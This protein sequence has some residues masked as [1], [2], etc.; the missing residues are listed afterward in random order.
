M[1]FSP[2]LY[3]EDKPFLIGNGL[4][5]GSI[6]AQGSKKWL[7]YLS[8]FITQLI[9]NMVEFLLLKKFNFFDTQLEN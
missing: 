4:F 6:I 2:L 8:I 5:L 3:L 9:L 7:L 1:D